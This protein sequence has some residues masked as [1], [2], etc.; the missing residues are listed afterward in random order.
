M[1]WSEVGYALFCIAAPMA[2]GVLVVFV[3]NLIERKARGARQQGAAQEAPPIEYH[4]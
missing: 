4:I 3:S 1:K 2:W